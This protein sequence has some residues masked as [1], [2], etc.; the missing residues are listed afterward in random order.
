MKSA[1]LPEFWE[2][3]NAL[4]KAI[5]ARADKAYAL[6]LDNPSHPGLMFKRVKQ[7]QP[8]YSARISLSYRALALVGDDVAT[9]FW[10]G[11]HD[12]YDQLLDQ[13]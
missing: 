8:L 4:P 6:W 12:E 2:R 9:W 13:F 3:Y 1:T 5:Q 11:P 7:S 10:I